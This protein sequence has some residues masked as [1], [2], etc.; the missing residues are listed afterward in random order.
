MT[1]FAKDPRPMPLTREVLDELMD[2]NLVEELT[3]DGSSFRA[4]LNKCY[5]DVKRMVYVR[6]VSL[7]PELGWDHAL[8]PVNITITESLNGLVVG[9]I[10]RTPQEL[11]NLK[12]TAISAPGATFYVST[13]GSDS[14][15]GLTLGTAFRSIWKAIDAGNA[16]NVPTKILISSGEYSR[17]NGFVGGTNA[18]PVVDMAFIADQSAG[19]RVTAGTWDVVTGFTLDA[20]YTNCYSKASVANCTGVIDR[21]TTNR[22]GNRPELT[23]VAT[24][25][26]CNVTPNSW[27]L[28]SSTLYIHRADS[29][30][31]TETN[32]RY[33]RDSSNY[34]IAAQVNVFNSGID[35]QGSNGVYNVFHINSPATSTPATLNIIVNYDCSFKYGGVYAGSNGGRGIGAINW[36]GGIVNINCNS[37]ANANDGFNLHNP[38]S[39]TNAKWLNLN[40]TGLDNGRG[41]QSVNGFTLHENCIGI[42]IAGVYDFNRG[43]TIHNIDNSKVYLLGTLV[44]NDQ[45]DASAGGGIPPVA[46]RM[47]G[48]AKAWCERVRIEMPPGTLA[49]QAAGST[50]A[51][52]LKDCPPVSQPNNG[53]GLITTYA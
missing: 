3:N 2:G 27:A 20:T 37:T 22:F 18:G 5:F 11:F 42:D 7:P 12:S 39:S 13:T 52:Y 6:T 31:P 53:P 45:G 24:A 14:N 28:V 38:Q 15:N 4:E 32:T 1:P 26:L 17:A 44:K 19:Y 23:Q 33:F 25:A 35:L 36:Y 10:D 40:C 29:A 49:Y 51:I 8:I 41:V 9:S 30:A 16:A 50:S 43:G 48:S 21:T 46:V 47:A 34:K